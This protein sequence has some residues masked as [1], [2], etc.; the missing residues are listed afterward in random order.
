MSRS[1]PAAVVAAWLCLGGAA[2]AHHSVGI[3]SDASKAFSL[4]GV[5]KEMDSLS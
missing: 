1:I 3:N 5:L 4:T 2:I